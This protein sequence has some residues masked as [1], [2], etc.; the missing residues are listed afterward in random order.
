MSHS[1]AAVRK[2]RAN[3]KD[4]IAAQKRARK[5]TIEGRASYLVAIKRAY[6][7][8][9]KLEF[10]LTTEFLVGLWK[11][12]EGKCAVTDTKMRLTLGNGR[13]P[14]S[15]SID[16]IDSNKGYLKTNIRFV[17]WQVNAMKF[18]L[19][20]SQLKDWCVRILKGLS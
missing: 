6:C 5:G 3:N 16:R 17:C 18:E 4:K 2:Y 7:R 15:I 1:V 14:E 12:Q 8:N 9:N 11:N 20:D 19:T 10:D 13:H